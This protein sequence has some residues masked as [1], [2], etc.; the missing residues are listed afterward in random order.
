MC[1]TPG[2]VNDFNYLD[3]PAIKKQASEGFDQGASISSTPE[4]ARI[5]LL[6]DVLDLV[7]RQNHVKLL[8][9]FKQESELLALTVLQLLTERG[10]HDQGR[11]VWFSLKYNTNQIL[12]QVA[13]EIPS[14]PSV[15]EIALYLTLYKAGLLDLIHIPHKGFG[16]VPGLE[17]EAADAFL[18]K[19][20]YLGLLPDFVRLRLLR[21][22]VALVDLTI[23]DAM[24]Q[25]G[26]ECWVLGVNCEKTLSKAKDHGAHGYITDRPEWL[27]SVLAT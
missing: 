3:L 22:A 8:I 21:T 25:R 26:I 15:S 14:S 11:V 6:K 27:T 4:R 17:V 13:P 12:R 1:G 24:K 19:S 23:F 10:L 7:V 9:E 5:P 20:T 2:H 18:Q 16:L